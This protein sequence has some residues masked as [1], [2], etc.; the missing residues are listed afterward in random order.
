MTVIGILP[1]A[2]SATRLHNLPKFLLPCPGGYL[3]NHH[4][5]AMRTAGAAKVW[6]GASKTTRPFVSPFVD[7][8]SIVATIDSQ[9]MT[10]TVLAG[11]KTAG[12]STVLLGLPDTYFD[13]PEVYDKLLHRINQFGAEI[14]IGLWRIRTD[15]RGKLGQVDTYGDRC[16]RIVDKD[17]TC[18]LPWCWG[19]IAFAPLF[20]EFIQPDMPHI[21][22]AL[23]A[24][25]DAGV[26]VWP[27]MMEG[28]YHD[29]GEWASYSLMCS[30]FVEEAVYVR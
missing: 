7:N 15:Q 27:V 26:K 20:W 9:T 10:Q 2:G 4:I 14:A 5:L 24:A 21:G 25:I 6:I 13:Y 18:V 16:T 1:A 23:Q 8:D 17:P 22:L 29:C 3:L 12:D 28:D 30:Q 11:R 19:A